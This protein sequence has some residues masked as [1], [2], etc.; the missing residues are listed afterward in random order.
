M[1]ASGPP[2][3]P[4]SATGGTGAT[5]GI[6]T[7]TGGENFTDPFPPALPPP[8]S[9]ASSS[10]L[11]GTGAIVGLA[12][13]AAALLVLVPAV[14]A[15]LARRR[16]RELVGR[17]AREKE[18]RAAQLHRAALSQSRLSMVPSHAPATL[19]RLSVAAQRVGATVVSAQLPV[20]GAGAGAAGPLAAAPGLHKRQSVVVDFAAGPRRA[21]VSYAAAGAAGGDPDV[22]VARP[23]AN[24]VL[25]DR[26]VHATLPV[27]TAAQ[28]GSF[29]D[30]AGLAEPSASAASAGG[31]AGAGAGAVAVYDE[32]EVSPPEL[33][34]AGGDGAP[35]LP[36]GWSR[37]LDEASGC[38]YF[39][40]AP[41]GTTQW[42]H[43][44]TAAHAAQL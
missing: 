44:A 2:T 43:P 41:S 35:A 3:A 37:H 22:L 40:H 36:A 31:G 11:G 14:W 33:E 8:E 42:E 34:E 24:A 26:R 19:R 28:Q 20:A 30:L 15:W 29:L 9:A 13:G 27:V 12:V 17:M 6:A 10:L 21:S 39:Y 1:S 23:Q 25:S 18:S 38:Y 7:G 4:P 32:G 16:R 5:G